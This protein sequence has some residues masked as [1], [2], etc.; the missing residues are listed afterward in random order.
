MVVGDKLRS[1]SVRLLRNIIHPRPQAGIAHR[2]VVL[3]SM[4]RAVGA[5][6]S[7]LATAF[8]TLDPSSISDHV[9]NWS[10]STGGKYLFQSFCLG[11]VSCSRRVANSKSESAS[12][13]RGGKSSELYGD[14]SAQS[15]HSRAMLKLPRSNSRS[16]RV[17]VPAIRRAFKTS[18]RWPRSGWN[19]WRISAHPKCELRSSA[20]RADRG[21]AQ[22]SHPAV[23]LVDFDSQYRFRLIGP[24]QQLF[25]QRWPM[26]FQVL[27]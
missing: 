11:L 9:Y 2:K 24:T 13:R 7:W 18:K 19:G 8:V 26:L 3:G 10:D 22:L 17:S 23:R 25:P 12:S 20:V 27:R 15:V 14:G 6:A 4:T 21:D 16:R 5:L 1:L